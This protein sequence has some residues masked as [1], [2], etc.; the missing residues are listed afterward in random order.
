MTRHFPRYFAERSVGRMT[1]FSQLAIGTCACAKPLFEARVARCLGLF[2][3]CRQVNENG[4]CVQCWSFP[5]RLKC[6]VG[7]L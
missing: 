6:S 5:S 3:C 1:R 4:P 7:E 2:S